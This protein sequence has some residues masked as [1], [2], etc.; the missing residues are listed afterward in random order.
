MSRIVIADDHAIVREGLKQIIARH[1]DLAVV[2]EA[3]SGP[4][5]LKKLRTTHCDVVLLDLSMPGRSGLEVLREIRSEH[6]D[7]PVL[8]LSVHPE[9]LYAV[10]AHRA[11]ASGYLTKESAPEQ[12][13]EAIR[14]V[15]RGGKYVSPSL[16][17][18]FAVELESDSDKPP[19]E[20]LSDREYQ[21]MCMLASGKTVSG[22]A[23]ELALSVPSISTYRARILA[24]MQMRNNAELA[25]YAIRNGLVD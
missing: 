14:K 6:K 7:L 8:I 9:E 3:S 10:R 4:E 25:H 19:H 1:S 16:A 18:R 21:V 11:G 13:V 12:L 24:K 17:E 2:A 5:L 23:E 22:I 15:S 20:K